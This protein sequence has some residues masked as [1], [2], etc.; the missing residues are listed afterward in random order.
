M[1]TMRV[2][3]NSNS[4][5]SLPSRMLSSGHT[6]QSSFT[7]SIGREYHVFAMALWQGVILLLLADDHHLPNWFP[8]CLFSANDPRLPDEWSFW[9]AESDEEGLQALWGYKQLIA[10]ATHYDGLLEREPEA[11][12]YFYE[13][14]TRRLNLD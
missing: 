6:L 12:R 4:G 5:Q 10:N 3:C 2:I 9:S 11:L 7:V 1:K 8:M 14:E 13:E